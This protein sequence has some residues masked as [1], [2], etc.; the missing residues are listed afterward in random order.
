MASLCETWSRNGGM[1]LHEA[2]QNEVKCCPKCF[3]CSAVRAGRNARNTCRRTRVLHRNGRGIQGIGVAVIKQRKVFL[4]VLLALRLVPPCRMSLWLGLV[5]NEVSR[6]PEWGTCLSLEG[7]APSQPGLETVA[8]ERNPP[9]ASLNH[10][11]E[12]L[13]FF[14]EQ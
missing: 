6:C 11:P 8:T 2:V 9:A 14:S 3:G 13:S 7:C 1:I 12:T 10:K 5:Q 4:C